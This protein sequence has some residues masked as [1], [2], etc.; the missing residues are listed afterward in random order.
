MPRA[1]SIR[2]GIARTAVG[3]TLMTAVMLWG[4]G[5][6]A[7]NDA[8]ALAERAKAVFGTPPAVA[9]N[10]ANP[11]TAEKVTLG[12]MLYFDARLS[13]NHDVSCNSC[14]PLDR[15]GAD[16]E[17]TSPGHRGQRGGRNSPTVYNAAPQ[18]A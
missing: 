11:V 17:A 10:P 8:A 7:G 16:G 6:T 12:R 4:G 15:F 3:L 1:T 13:K 14:H 5:A 2:P 9:D 18:I